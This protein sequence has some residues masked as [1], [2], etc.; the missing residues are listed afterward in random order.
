MMTVGRG[1]AARLPAATASAQV[2]MAEI[3]Q[4]PGKIK[5]SVSRNRAPQSSYVLSLIASVEPGSPT[6]G[7]I[8]N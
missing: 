4:F 1:V 8:E 7:Y 3:L 2:M 5:M 6:T